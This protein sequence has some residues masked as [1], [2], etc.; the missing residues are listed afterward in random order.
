[1]ASKKIRLELT[2]AQLRMVNS[3]LAREEAEDHDPD[4]AYRQEVMERTRQVVWDAMIE[5]GMTS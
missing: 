2:P 1:M 5:N 4:E 3:S